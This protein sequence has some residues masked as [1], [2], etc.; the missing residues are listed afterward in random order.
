MI[1]FKLGVGLTKRS[2]QEMWCLYE[3]LGNTE[4]GSCLTVSLHAKR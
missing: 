1:F 4:V 2:T 3:N